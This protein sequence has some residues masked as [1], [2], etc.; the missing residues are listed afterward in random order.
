MSND[1]QLT[2]YKKLL[3][4]IDEQFKEDIN[5]PEIE[6]ACNYSYRNINRIF[7]AINHE[8]IGKYIKRIRLERAAQYLKFSQESITDIA[9]DV[10]FGDVAAL[11]KA[12]KN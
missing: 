3:R 5:I 8:T 4:F 1:T 10:G 7:E 6:E 2:R 9:Y 11:S 12:F